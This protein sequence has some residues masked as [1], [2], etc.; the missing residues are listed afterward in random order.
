MVNLNAKTLVDVSTCPITLGSLE[1]AV[2]LHPCQHKIDAIAAELIH[3]KMDERTGKCIQKVPCSVCQVDVESYHVD[4]TVRNVATIIFSLPEPEKQLSSIFNP[5][6]EI[7]NLKSN[8]KLDEKEQ[9]AQSKNGKVV[10]RFGC[11]KDKFV[12]DM[13]NSVKLQFNQPFRLKFE[14]TNYNEKNSL[15]QTIYI[16][17][18][19][20][21]KVIADVFFRCKD[22][23]KV[24]KIMRL[25][26]LNINCLQC[27]KT[28]MSNIS[29]RNIVDLRRLAAVI[30]PYIEFPPRRQAKIFNLLTK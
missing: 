20:N 13:P 7:E 3:G 30:Q 27:Y 9:I 14:N 12:L 21:N 15:F 18:N 1:K 24:K 10:D 19:E 2:S 11:A 23:E 28:G 29:C 17:R 4:H 16:T 6:K 22:N 25:Y 26:K 5:P 8:I